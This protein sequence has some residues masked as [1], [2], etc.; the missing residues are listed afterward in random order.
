MN[1]DK[2][3][4]HL[5]KRKKGNFEAV[6]TKSL[7]IHTCDGN[8]DAQQKILKNLQTPIDPADSATKQFVEELLE[9]HSKTLSSLNQS[10]SNIITRINNLEKV[11]SLNKNSN[12]KLGKK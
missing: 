3:G 5:N 4:H 8:L 11:I 2:F 12:N 7:W 6:S 10:V 9:R 1:V